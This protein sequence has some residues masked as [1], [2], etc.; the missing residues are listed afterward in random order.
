[1]PEAGTST[2][3]RHRR[4]ASRLRSASLT[5]PRDSSHGARSRRRRTVQE[6]PPASPTPP[7]DSS[8]G[9][10]EPDAARLFGRSRPHHRLRRGIPHTERRSRIPQDC[11]GGATASAVIAARQRRETGHHKLTEYPAIEYRRT[12]TGQDGGPGG[13]RQQTYLNTVF[14]AALVSV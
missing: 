3:D 5:P 8:H 11:P 1:M 13:Q 6:E 7:R 2:P 14:M 9:A 12:G 10:A 4:A